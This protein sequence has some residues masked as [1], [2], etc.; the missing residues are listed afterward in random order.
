[1]PVVTDRNGKA[2]V[3]LEFSAVDNL[4]IRG[5]LQHFGNQELSHCRDTDCILVL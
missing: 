2:V 3:R 5:L 1:M 4:P